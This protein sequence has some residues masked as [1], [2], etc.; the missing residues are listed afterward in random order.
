[1][2]RAR[3]QKVYIP[4]GSV[5]TKFKMIKTNQGVMEICKRGHFWEQGGPNDKKQALL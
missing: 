3:R 5:C 4:R 2:L 1:M